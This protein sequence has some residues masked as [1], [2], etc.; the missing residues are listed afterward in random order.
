MKE[1]FCFFLSISISLSAFAESIVVRGPNASALEYAA[2]LKATSNRVSPSQAY[3]KEHPSA[4]NSQELLQKFAS[5]QEAFLKESLEEAKLQFQEVLQMATK[6]D[7]RKTQRELLLS[8]HLRLAQLSQSSQEA[9]FQ[10]KQSL[11][12]GDDLSPDPRLFPPPLIEK[13]NLLRSTSTK[14]DISKHVFSN[15]A[16]ILLNGVIFDLNENLKIYPGEY[17]VTVLSDSHRFQTLQLSAKQIAVTNWTTDGLVQ[18]DCL[19]HQVSLENAHA[20]LGQHCSRKNFGLASSIQSQPPQNY[21]PLPTVNTSSTKPFYKSG[22]FWAGVGAVA[23]AV[24]VASSQNKKK[25]HETTPSQ[26]YGF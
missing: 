6:D 19:N 21:V 13:W 15:G 26:T 25:D 24:V 7:W 8:A 11:T 22:W 1:L 2:Y 23:V 16:L 9:E 3:L 5:A 14:V 20:F 17:R 10:L 18:G 4:E 12:L